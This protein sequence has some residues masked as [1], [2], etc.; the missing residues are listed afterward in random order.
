MGWAAP[1]GQHMNGNSFGANVSARVLHSG[2]CCLR[3]RQTDRSD[4]SSKHMAGRVK[5]RQWVCGVCE[6]GGG[7]IE[8]SS[9]VSWSGVAWGTQNGCPNTSSGEW[10]MRIRASRKRRAEA[11]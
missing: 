8:G 11:S 3:W 9:V 1:A 4:S 10:E 5:W 7:F 6:S 2:L